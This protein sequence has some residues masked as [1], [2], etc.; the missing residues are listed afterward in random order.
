MKSTK[1]KTSRISESIRPPDLEEQC[2]QGANVTPNTGGSSAQHA[3]G[4]TGAGGQQSGRWT[5]G[6][7]IVNTCGHSP[8]IVAID[9]RT[10]SGLQWIADVNRLR[11]TN[12]HLIA[13]A[14]ELYEALERAIDLVER[15]HRCIERQEWQKA[16]KNDRRVDLHSSG[17]HILLR[18]DKRVY[19]LRF[20]MKHYPY[21]TPAQARAKVESR[22]ERRCQEE[23]ARGWGAH[24]DRFPKDFTFCW[25]TK[26]LRK[27]DAAAA[28]RRVY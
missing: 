6:P 22:L 18:P 4:E 19:P 28:Q 20:T 24:Y 12:A 17:A 10:P 15:G 11:P 3:Q 1:A 8:Q 23:R 25:E 13:A 26:G 9:G 7:W 27:L 5:P 16:W 21:R 14:P 2:T